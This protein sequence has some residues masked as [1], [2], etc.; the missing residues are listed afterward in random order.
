M[1][2][3]FGV[4]KE[5]QSEKPEYGYKLKVGYVV[6]VRTYENN[7]YQVFK[8]EFFMETCHRRFFYWFV[9]RRAKYDTGFLYHPYHFL[10]QLLY[11]HK[12]KP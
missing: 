6:L 4:Y 10:S 9:L 11:I 2:L 3:F 12:N 5:T 8:P 7:A 1:R